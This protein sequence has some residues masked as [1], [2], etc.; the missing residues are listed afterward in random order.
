[1][2]NL[3]SI[4]IAVVKFKVLKVLRTDSTSNTPFWEVFGSLLPQM[5]SNI[6]ETLTK[7][8]TLANKRFVW[9]FLKDMEKNGP[10]ISFFGPILTPRFPM[11]IAEIEKNKH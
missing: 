2:V 8:T 1:M 10:K 9:K 5:W 3:I 4:A 7:S 11:K 6:A